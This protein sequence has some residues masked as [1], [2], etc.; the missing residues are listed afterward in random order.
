VS[1]PGILL[2]TALLLLLVAPLASAR[3]YKLGR[4]WSR[5]EEHGYAFRPCERFEPIPLPPRTKW[6]VQ[7]FV[8][9]EK[10]D[11]ASF[12][13]FSA[14]LYVVHI[15]EKPEVEEEDE[16]AEDEGEGP[17]L[18]EELKRALAQMRDRDSFEGAWEWAEMMWD[19][20]KRLSEVQKV[21]LKTKLTPPGK[22]RAKSGKIEAEYWTF[23]HT[24][25]FY[26]VPKMGMA[27]I[28]PVED[29]EIGL[30]YSHLA[31]EFEDFQKAWLQSIASFNLFDRAGAEDVGDEDSV[32]EYDGDAFRR[33]R[34]AGLTE[35][36]KA[37]DTPNYLILHHVDDRFA[38]QLG[39]RL[40]ACRRLYERMFPPKIEKK[41][42]SVVRVCKDRDEYHEYNG[43]P[44]SAGYWSPTDRELVF[45]EDRSGGKKDTFSVLH[46]EGF[47]QYIHYCY[48]ELAPHSWYNEGHGDYFSG[49]K[50][51]DKHRPIE[52]DKFLWR[53]SIAQQAAND[54]KLV[55]LEQFVRFTQ[56]Q[57]YNPRLIGQ[58][59]AQ[60]WAFIYFLRESKRVK[61]E[62]R[63]ILDVYFETI[64]RET[65]RRR[66]EEENEGES[67]LEEDDDGEGEGESD[68]ES[69]PEKELEDA[70][71]EIG[72]GAAS[73]QFQEK[74]EILR[75]A[76][77]TAFSGIDMAELEAAFFEFCRNNFRDK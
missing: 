50:F 61:P 14:D 21:K 28:V 16:V 24:P 22:T 43:P 2:T 40:E 41:A 54:G 3:I 38:Q 33:L 68:E 34:K 5:N 53:T 72:F 64:W 65:E 35:G 30:F 60:G 48:G 74:E 31:G 77:D 17:D 7:R 9:P 12:T 45:Y 56:R 8:G 11:D 63:K 36:W 39:M 71:E 18:P 47:H 46:H 70:L 44:G 37:L 27:L 62:W 57:Y 75:V 59:Y 42:V 29:G 58:N 4:D 1:G 69:D 51:D 15:P 13:R 66:A 26:D 10:V 55:P 32:S 6:I 67:E 52:G 73:R 76:V 20:A 49:V 23:T 19:G 25:R